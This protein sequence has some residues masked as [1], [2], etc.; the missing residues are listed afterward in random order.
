[1]E[2]TTR[3]SI[4]CRDRAAARK[5]PRRLVEYRCRRR[6]RECS[7]VDSRASG[8][9]LLDRQSNQRCIEG[10]RHPRR[11]LD[12]PDFARR[13]TARV[14]HRARPSLAPIFVRSALRA[15]SAREALRDSQVPPPVSRSPG[16]ALP[17]FPGCSTAAS[18]IP[19]FDPPER[20]DRWAPELRP[21]AEFPQT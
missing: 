3:R 16:I 15:A 17:R 7:P 18:H 10:T 14:A 2:R 5:P 6:S 19:Q 8:S 4:P 11:V 9:R 21:R 13:A 20:V 12:A 1:M